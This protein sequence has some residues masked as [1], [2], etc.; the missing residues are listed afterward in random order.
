[1]SELLVSHMPTPSTIQNLE[2][3][4]SCLESPRY[5]EQP[6]DPSILPDTGTSLDL[7]LLDWSI[8]DSGFAFTEDLFQFENPS[9][10]NASRSTPS[11]LCLLPSRIT[12]ALP[13]GISLSQIS[14][15]LAHRTHILAF[16]RSTNQYTEERDAWLCE[17]NIVSFITS[18]FNSFHAHTPML[19]APTWKIGTAKSYLVMAV[20][21][22]GAVYTEDVSNRQKAT[23]LCEVAYDYAWYNTSDDLTVE[24]IQAAYLSVLLSTFFSPAHKGQPRL[25][26]DQLIR[27]ARRLG[28]F[29]ESPREQY[30]EQDW[31]QWINRE[32][33]LRTAYILHLFEACWC[34]FFRQLPIVHVYEIRL[35]LPT[36]ED[37][38]EAPTEE[39]WRQ[40]K[41]RSSALTGINYPVLLAMYISQVPL[42]VPTNISVMGAFVILHGILLI[43]WQEKSVHARHVT[44][45]RLSH[46]DPIHVDVLGMCQRQ[47]ANT[48]FKRWWRLWSSTVSDPVA[49]ASSGLYRE[50]AVAYRLLGQAMNKDTGF[51]SRHVFK[52]TDTGDWPLTVPRLL[53]RLIA[54]MDTGAYDT[55]GPEEIDSVKAKLEQRLEELE[56]QMDGNDE[57]ENDVD[58]IVITSVMKAS[59]KPAGI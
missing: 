15:I 33:R 47:K 26:T 3:Q 48:A 41:S 43:M 2:F 30:Y 11:T 45:N 23:E 27:A 10:I 8:F 1:M 13:S 29:E 32:T 4:G 35:P 5:E 18:Y 59:Q 51:A 19:H 17:G 9:P 7:N 54:L 55:M 46:A 39:Q 53:S 57:I 14:P 37:V 36:H 50:R 56:G 40:K 49:S 52:L 22:V 44:L 38:F 21:L 58:H 28:L 42:E 20:A 24:S 16:L 12:A 25:R 31:R 34:I 6:S